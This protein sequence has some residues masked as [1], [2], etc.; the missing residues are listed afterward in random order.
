MNQL[1]QKKLDLKEKL[2][3]QREKILIEAEQD[4]AVLTARIQDKKD[5]LSLL[6]KRITESEKGLDSSMADA[7]STLKALEEDI[8]QAEA[9]KQGLLSS[10]KSLRKNIESQY[11]E[12]NQIKNEIQERGQYLKEQ[13][14]IISTTIEKGNERLLELK[15]NIGESE[16]KKSRSLSEKLELEDAI[17]ERTKRITELDEALLIIEQEYE[18]RTK[19][20][21]SKINDKKLELQEAETR[22]QSVT[23]ETSSKLSQLKEKEISLMTKQDVIRKEKAELVVEKRRF[24]SVQS[25]YN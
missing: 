23:E 4:D 1:S 8:K 22:L 15:D 5:E 11:V 16:D 7:I 13:E 19:V 18:E 21:E 2:L 14:W 12:L 20:L 9:D 25:L 24:N 3:E 17:F 10:Q 6:E